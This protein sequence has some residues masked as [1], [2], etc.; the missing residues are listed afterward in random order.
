M[1]SSVDFNAQTEFMA[2]KVKD[3]TLDYVLSPKL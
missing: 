1:N 2:V 3:K